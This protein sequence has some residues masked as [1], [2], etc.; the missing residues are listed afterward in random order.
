MSAN[1]RGLS[2]EANKDVWLWRMVI[3]AL[4]L[5]ALIAI[6]GAIWLAALGVEIPSAAVA[7]GSVAIGGLAGLL[8]PSPVQ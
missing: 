1:P 5:I 6:V 2:P 4:A 3:G 7:L 8:A